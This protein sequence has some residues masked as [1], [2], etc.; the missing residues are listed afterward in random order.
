MTEP[1]SNRSIRIEESAIGSAIV[2]GDGNTIYVIQHT[3]EGYGPDYVGAP[4]K[5]K[6]LDI[7]GFQA[8]L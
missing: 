1:A 3:T 6:N 4:E 8:F 5:V 2:S 7:H